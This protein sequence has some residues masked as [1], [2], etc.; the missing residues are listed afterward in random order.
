VAHSRAALQR[1]GALRSEIAEIDLGERNR[2]IRRGRWM[3]SKHNQR[4]TGQIAQRNGVKIE[5][6]GGLETKKRGVLCCWWLEERLT[7]P[8]TGSSLTAALIAV[9]LEFPAS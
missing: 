4:Q 7:D 9:M 8:V 6:I 1:E 3:K 5:Q 2:N